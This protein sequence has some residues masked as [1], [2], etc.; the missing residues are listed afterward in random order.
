M[1]EPDRIKDYVAR[2]AEYLVRWNAE[3]PEVPMDINRIHWRARRWQHLN[4]RDSIS[5]YRDI[6]SPIRGP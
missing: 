1:H 6:L 5:P 3:H 2:Y 4:P